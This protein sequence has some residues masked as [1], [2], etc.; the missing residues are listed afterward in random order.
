MADAYQ[1]SVAE[2]QARTVT[3]LR[4]AAAELGSVRAQLAGAPAV[5]GGQAGDDVAANAIALFRSRGTA[6]LDRAEQTL[7]DLAGRVGVV[8]DVYTE[9]DA[10][11]A[12]RYAGV[13][14]AESVG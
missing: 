11:A 12:T 7:D 2:V 3:G 5:T 8:M 6:G 13:G 1:V 14:G 10:A 9:G 4:T